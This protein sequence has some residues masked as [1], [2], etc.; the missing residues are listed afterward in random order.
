MKIQNTL[1]F[2]FLVGVNT[3]YNQCSS[4]CQCCDDT[5]WEQKCLDDETDVE[6]RCLIEQNSYSW[7]GSVICMGLIA[8]I[9]LIVHVQ[10]RRSIA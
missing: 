6:F 7:V 4:D 8:F 1:F 10:N 5:K 9:L 3:T 2:L